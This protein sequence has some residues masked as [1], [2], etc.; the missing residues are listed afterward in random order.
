MSES[1]LAK[2]K[3]EPFT[4]DPAAQSEGGLAAWVSARCRQIEF[5]LK[6]F[7][8][9]P[10]MIAELESEPYFAKRLRKDY[11]HCNAVRSSFRIPYFPFFAQ[12]FFPI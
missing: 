9:M 7:P 12:Q 4:W 3:D 2:V 11:H 1:D 5:L 6:M 10:K 8:E